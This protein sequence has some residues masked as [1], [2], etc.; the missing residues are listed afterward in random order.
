MLSWVK[1]LHI[2][3]YGPEDAA[4]VLVLH[5]WG[6]NA[7]LMRALATSLQDGYRV[8]NIDLP[9]HGQSPL[10]PEPWGIPEHAALVAALITREIGGPVHF[11]GHS[12]GGRIAL[13]MASDPALASHIQSLT[14]I[15]PSGVKP[16]RTLKYHLKKGIATALKAPFQI[17]PRPLKAYGLDWMRHTLVW[18]LL[19]SSDYSQLK[20]V[21][22]EVFV[23]T[24]N[25]HLDDRLANIKKPALLFWGTE[26][27]AISDYQMEVLQRKIEGSELVRLEGASHYGHLD[28]PAIVSAGLRHFLDHLTHV[29]AT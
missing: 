10:P 18:R 8:F 9:G 5:G 19:G 17:L 6:S 23:K 16:R 29:R 7:G 3:R 2:E 25:C 21:M 27:E 11:V 14:L 22:R 12:N 15:S 13:Y 26:D 4:P 24:V 1:N 28:Q 20:G